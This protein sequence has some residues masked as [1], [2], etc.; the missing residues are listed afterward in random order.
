MP[1][2]EDRVRLRVK[3][4]ALAQPAD[5]EALFALQ[6]ALLDRSASSSQKPLVT[7]Q[8]VDETRAPHLRVCNSLFV[9]RGGG[10]CCTFV[11]CGLPTRG[12]HEEPGRTQSAAGG[13]TELGPAKTRPCRHAN[14]PPQEQCA[15]GLQEPW[16]PTRSCRLQPLRL[17]ASPLAISGPARAR[18]DV[19]SSPT[20]QISPALA[21]SS[22][23]LR[24]VALGD[25]RHTISLIWGKKYRE[26]VKSTMQR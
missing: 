22:A 2:I 20:R 9:T 18:C 1:A 8:L 12:S 24:A 3:S 6:R 5:D 25:M 7:M 23:R 11:W 10:I 26:R 21:A 19:S 15:R 4:N 17:R 14:G 16:P 13:C